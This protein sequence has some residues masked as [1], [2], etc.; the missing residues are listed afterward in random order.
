LKW[1]DLRISLDSEVVFDW[2]HLFSVEGNTGPYIQYSYAR[3]QNILAKADVSEKTGSFDPSILTHPSELSLL[4]QL[5]HFPEVVQ[6]AGTA[7]SPHMICQFAFELAQNFS[8]FYE[9]VP[10]LSSGSAE[11]TAR[12]GLVTAVGS[13]L[14]ISLRLLGINAPARL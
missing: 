6:E 10:V 11:R 2:D 7:L 3:T 14:G 13:T 4:R 1:N 12:L 8:R 9:A 5:V